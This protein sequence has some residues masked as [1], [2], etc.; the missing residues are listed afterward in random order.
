MMTKVFS[1][2]LL[3]QLVTACASSGDNPS[4]QRGSARA[5]P[6]AYSQDHFIFNKPQKQR[7]ENDFDFYYKHCSI[8]DRKPFPVGAIWQCTLPY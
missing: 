1:L 2:I 8:D 6:S 5:H 4:S 7:E 3:A